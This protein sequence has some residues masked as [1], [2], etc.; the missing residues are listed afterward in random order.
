MS[1]WNF[2]RFDIG[3]L[4]NLL[5]QR[6]DFEDINILNFSKILLNFAIVFKIFVLFWV[7][8]VKIYTSQR[9]FWSLENALLDRTTET[10]NILNAFSLQNLET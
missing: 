4:A 5:R 10:T 3:I 9:K 8:V 6:I 7:F 2:L 1:E